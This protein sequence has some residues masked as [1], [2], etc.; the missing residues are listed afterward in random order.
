MRSFILRIIIV[1]FTIFLVSLLMPGVHVENFW[2][3][4]IFSIV[5]GLINAF[6]RP[7]ISLLT[8]PI[9]ILTLGLFSLVIN[10]FLFWIVTLFVPGVEVDSIIATFLA[11]LIVWLVSVIV[12]KFLKSKKKK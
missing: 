7:L 4:I 12:N 6:I 1:A 10:A 8:L 5:L 2:S 9:K 3:A 11:A